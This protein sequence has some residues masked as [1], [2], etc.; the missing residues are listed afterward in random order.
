[1]RKVALVL[2]HVLEAAAAGLV[3]GVLL[4]ISSPSMPR[5]KYPITILKPNRAS[6]ARRC[7]RVHPSRQQGSRQS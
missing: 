2:T 3:P 1:V 7:W 5:P 6:R 4:S